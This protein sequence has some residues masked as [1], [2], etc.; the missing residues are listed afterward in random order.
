MI[1]NIKRYVPII[2]F[3]IIL[4]LFQCIAYGFDINFLKLYVLMPDGGIRYYLTSTAVPLALAY[5]V[6]F[7]WKQ[8][9]N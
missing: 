8:K 9:L 6:D 7:V 1:Q 4:S 2:P 5:L 3:L